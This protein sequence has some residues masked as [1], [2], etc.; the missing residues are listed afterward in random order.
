MTGMLDDI[1][2][3]DLTTFLSGPYCTMILADMGADVIK[4]ETPRSEERR[5]G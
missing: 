5:G 2:V 4:I 1:K 3:L